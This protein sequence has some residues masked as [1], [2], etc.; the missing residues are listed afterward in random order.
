MLVDSSAYNLHF[1]KILP[2]G[3]AVS[4][5]L[6]FEFVYEPVYSLNFDLEASIR[7]I[8]RCVLPFEISFGR[9]A[10]L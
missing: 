7:D 10:F 8:G 2:S 6:F 5:L 9:A 4:F 1:R 3:F